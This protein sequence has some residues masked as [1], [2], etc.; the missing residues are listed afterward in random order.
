MG[1]CWL[2]MYCRRLDAEQMMKTD[3]DLYEKAATILVAANAGKFGPGSPAFINWLTINEMPFELIELFRHLSPLR[4]TWLGAG[5]LYDEARIVS[6]NDLLPEGLQSDLLIV[7]SAPNGDHIAVDIADGAVGYLCHEADWQKEGARNWFIAVS[8][9]LGNYMSEINCG[10]S[11]PDDY[12]E[13]R[14]A[15]GNHAE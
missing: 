11:L 9:S 1:E 10:G 7:G 12:W 13:A 5:G 8:D 2:G 3:P 6:I 15:A 14:K 4:E